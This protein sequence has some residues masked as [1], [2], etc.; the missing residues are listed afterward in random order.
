MSF[1]CK[2]GQKSTQ[3]NPM[4]SNCAGRRKCCVGRRRQ[5]QNVA[6]KP[7]PAPG[8]QHRAA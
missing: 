6:S 2:N 8:A 4:N 3:V 5:G 7:R 1:G